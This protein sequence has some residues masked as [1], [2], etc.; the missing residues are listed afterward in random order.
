MLNKHNIFICLAE[1]NIINWQKDGQ[2]EVE[3]YE[4]N[5][6]LRSVI[7]DESISNSYELASGQII[8]K[9]YS[10]DISSLEQVNID[11]SNS[12]ELGMEIQVVG[13]LITWLLSHSYIILKT[14][15]LFRLKKQS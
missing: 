2:E 3:N 10:Y 5:H 14:K 1:N 15:K 4:H 12:I 11:Y 8:E 13:I 7:A 9:E 6:I